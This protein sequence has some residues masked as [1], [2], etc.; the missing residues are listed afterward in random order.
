MLTRRL[1][2][3][4]RFESCDDRRMDEGSSVKVGIA[5]MDDFGAAESLLSVRE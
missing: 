2:E 4:D 1:D 3:R 5:G